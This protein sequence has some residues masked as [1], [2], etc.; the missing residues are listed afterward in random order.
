MPTPRGTIG[1]HTT[2]V[3]RGTPFWRGADLEFL[4]PRPHAAVIIP[5]AFSPVAKR[6]SVQGVGSGRSHH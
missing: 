3:G 6:S 2:A 1:D 4:I 5:L